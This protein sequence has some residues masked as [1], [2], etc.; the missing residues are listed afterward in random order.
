MR[1]WFVW[2]IIA[3]LALP[4]SAQEDAF[5]LPAALYVLTNEGQISRYGLGTEGVR[6]I[7]P[8]TPEETF[9]VDFGVAPDGN[10]LAYRT[11]GALSLYNIYSEEHIGIDG[12]QAG[13]PAVRGRGAT[14]DWSP[15]GDAIAVTTETG[16]RVYFNT[17]AELDSSQTF[18]PVD[19]MEG[20]F[21]QV[22]WSP[23]GG[24]LAAEAEGDVW[25]FY[26]R[27]N[28]TLI[29][30]SAIPSSDGIAWTEE[31]VVAFAPAEGGLRLMNLNIA[32]TQSVLLDETW[33]YHLP[34]M[35]DDGTLTVFGLQKGDTVPEGYGRLI[36]LPAGEPRIENLSELSIELAGMRWMP[37]DQLLLAFR[38]G[39]LA[40]VD[41]VTAN[42]FTLPISNA[43]AYDWGP[44]P[45]PVNDTPSLSSPLFFLAEDAAGVAQVWRLA[46]DGTPA[47]AL[48]TATEPVVSFAVAPDASRFAYVSGGTL[49]A[50]SP[51]G[52]D[53]L[54]LAQLSASPGESP[55]VT[56]PAF[57]PD[58]QRIAYNDGGIW[59]V[60]AAGGE[61]Q[62]VVADE[63]TEGFERHFLDPVFAPN[64][65][66]MLVRVQREAA[67]VPGILDTT[68]G[69]VIEIAVEQDAR[70]LTDGRILLY[71]SGE[72]VRP[73]GLSIAGTGSANQPA[74]F[75][76]DFV[77]VQAARETAPNQL[78]LV[79]PERLT[80][81]QL[82]RIA[83]FDV[84]TGTLTAGQS[85][86]F[87]VEPLLSPDGQFAAGYIYRATPSEGTDDGRGPLTVR[88]LETGEQFAVSTPPAIW[89]L[90]W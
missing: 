23:E 85:G 4:V 75:L 3:L 89:N 47:Q 28:K 33:T 65:G 61:P 48:T 18:T 41:P 57:S 80:G 67:D 82:L 20:A 6:T 52:T 22:I 8:G 12:A 32:N 68:T 25:W 49:F 87:M 9:V 77:P 58:G 69:E 73:G 63:M 34:N 88:N 21:V 37:D 11:E 53:P 72:G 39:A 7:T 74:Q 46:G 1:R 45:L 70:W 50:L 76:P 44:G 35:R 40:L 19:L 5:N 15:T 27:E 62:L 59:T 79:L 78:R 64:I 86:G 71:D 42:G 56:Q 17:E 13:V 83:A 14:I 30:T 24:Y 29:L 81:P 84:S 26:R 43:V 90:S 60:P 66:A 10:W 2:V 38:G 16:G 36:G 55:G 51:G 54:E 31:G